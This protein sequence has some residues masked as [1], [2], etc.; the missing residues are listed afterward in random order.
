MIVLLPT[1]RL[2]AMRTWDGVPGILAN[3]PGVGSVFAKMINLMVMRK[4]RLY[5]W[6]NIWAKEEIV[7]ELLGELQA[8]QVAQIVLNWLENPAELER[9]RERLKSVRGQAG[10][11]W[12]MAQIIDEQISRELLPD[13]S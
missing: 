7:P 13:P 11:A 3:L 2:D 4:K 8:E 9:I 1:Q 6:P 10:A 5:A 12:K